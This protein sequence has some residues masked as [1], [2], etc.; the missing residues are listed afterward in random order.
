ML[1]LLVV[2][3]LLASVM[4]L[5]AC[6]SPLG[7]DEAGETEPATTPS[8]TIDIP[9]LRVV[10]PTAVDPDDSS[11][12]STPT[13][14]FVEVP[15][16]YVVQDGDTLYSIAA[17]FGLELAEIVERN[18]LSDPNDIQVGQELQLPDPPSSE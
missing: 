11:L 13:P 16:T 6:S 8:P 1:K 10:T 9:L 14:E 4:S 7:P 12:E 18:Q 17:R 2:F 5:G 3:T 15:A